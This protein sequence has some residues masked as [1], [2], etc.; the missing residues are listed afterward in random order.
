M[1]VSNSPDISQQKINDLYQL[2]E[3]ILTYIDELL[4]STKLDWAYH[5]HKLELTLNKLKEKDLNIILKFFLR[6]TKMEYLGFWVTCNGWKP[7]Y[8]QY[9][10]YKI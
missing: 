3:F 6:K 8:K 10:Q 5:V 7:I 1:G 9:K 4:V 2:F